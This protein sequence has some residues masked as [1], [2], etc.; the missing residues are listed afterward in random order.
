[1][2]RQRNNAEYPRQDAR[3]LTTED[4]TR[5]IPKTEDILDLAVRVIDQ[6]SAY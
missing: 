4:V 5:D 3:R 2:R 1:L 6:M